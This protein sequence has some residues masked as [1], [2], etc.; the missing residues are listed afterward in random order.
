MDLPED[1][2]EHVAWE[3][4]EHEVP[5]INDADWTEPRQQLPPGRE[6]NRVLAIRTLRDKRSAGHY[7]FLTSDQL[8]A[9][10]VDDLKSGLNADTDVTKQPGVYIFIS[11][12]SQKTIKVGETANL[13]RRIGREHMRYGKG[14]TDSNLRGYFGAREDDWP[15]PLLDQEIVVLVLPL[16]NASE[17][18]RRA[19]EEGLRSMLLPEIDGTWDRRSHS[20]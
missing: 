10:A 8:H 11:L 2:Q 6:L 19:V 7:E 9:M 16:P 12:I 18:E 13:R 15:M 4:L 20:R 3:L 17:Q 14:H 1:E 5:W